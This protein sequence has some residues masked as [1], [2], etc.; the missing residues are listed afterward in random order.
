[1]NMDDYR[2]LAKGGPLE[3]AVFTAAMSIKLMPK[4]RPRMTKGG[5]VFTPE[6]TRIFEKAVTDWAKGLDWPTVTYPIRVELQL[7]E[8]LD[9]DIPRFVY[10]QRG[11]IDNVAKAILDALNKILYK[12]DRQIAELCIYRTFADRE[13]FNLTLERIGL[14]K[15]ENTNYLKFVKALK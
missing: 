3:Q 12:D 1:M 14:S 11:D 9:T 10:P 5:R 6:A 13:G 8:K 4:E 15:T 2:A 7:Y